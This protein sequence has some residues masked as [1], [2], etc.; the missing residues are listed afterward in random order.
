[1][2]L[3]SNRLCI[4]PQRIH[5][6]IKILET[7]TFTKSQGIDLDWLMN[8]GSL[9]SVVFLKLYDRRYLD[10]RMEKDA[11]EPWN[12]KNEAD[13]EKY[14]QMLISNGEGPTSLIIARNSVG[15]SDN[16][17]SDEDCGSDLSDDE[18]EIQ[19]HIEEKFQRWTRCWFN[20][21]VPVY[22][23]LHIL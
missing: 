4:S 12:P 6:T 18:V 15:D 22:C 11:K 5:A 9:S 20:I 16:G 13:V 19:W 7:F 2:G 10:E 21:E 14:A 3:C 17:S 23:R 1:M 8:D